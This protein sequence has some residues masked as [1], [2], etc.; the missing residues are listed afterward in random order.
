M[1]KSMPFILK[2]ASLILV[3]LATAKISLSFATVAGNATLIWIP[4]GIALAVVLIGGLRYLPSVFAG[5]FITSILLNNPLVINL[6]AAIGNTLEAYVGYILLNQYSSFNR[7]LDSPKDFFLLIALGG[8]LAPIAS[9][10]FGALALLAENY[11]SSDMLDKVA[12]GWWRGDVIGITYF[13]PIVLLLLQ[14]RAFPSTLASTLEKVALWLIS[15]IIGQMVFLDWTPP[16]QLLDTKLSGTAWIFL[17]IIWASQRTGRRNTAILQLMFLAQGLA[18]AY[19]RIGLFADDVTNYGMMN[20][21]AFAMLLAT[22]GMMMAM[23]KLENINATQKIKLVNTQL[24]TMIE[25]IPDAVFFKDG[26]GRWLVANETAKKLFKLDETQWYGKTDMELVTTNPEFR[27]THEASLD[28]DE[29]TWK[30]GELTLFTQTATGDDGLMHEYEMRKVPVL[31]N[32]GDRESLVVIGR[33]ITQHKIAQNALRDSEL[34]W[35][36]AI[37][38][39]DAG[40]WEY[41]FQTK[42]NIASKHLMEILGFDVESSELVHPLNDWGE[43]L[44]PKSKARTDVAFQAIMSNQS[45]NYVVEQEVRCED[46][47][48]KWLLTRGMVVERDAD[49]KPLLMIGT[50]IDITERQLA[51]E[52]FHSTLKEHQVEIEKQNDELRQAQSELKVSHD[53]YQDLYDFSPTGY[54]TITAQG[55]ITEINLKAVSML[56]LKRTQLIQQRLDQ[57]VADEDKLRLQ[58]LLSGIIKTKVVYGEEIFELK[59]LRNDGS[60][61]DAKLICLPIEDAN[62][63]QVLRVSLT[64]ITKLKQSEIDLRIAAIAFESQEGMFVTDANCMILR[65]NKAF[66]AMTGYTSEDIVG[67]KPNKL[68]SGRHDAAFYAQIWQCIHSTGSWQG[69]VWNK[70]KQG[71][72]Y[73]ERLT[74]TSVT[75]SKGLVSN[76]VATMIDITAS[77]NQ[78]MQH[79]ANEKILRDTL[80]RE[81]HH[82]IKN[83]LQGVAGLLRNSVA[84]NPQLTEPLT[85][86]ISQVNSISVIHGLQG[87]NS[88][89]NIP[90]CDLVREIATNNQSLWQ[91]SITLDLPSSVPHYR[92]IETETVPLALVLNELI[93]NAI[94]H[95]KK[96]AGI[97]IALSAPPD[98]SHPENSHVLITITNAGSLSAESSALNA[99]VAGIGLK[100]VASLLPSEGATLSWVQ[101]ADHVNTVLQLE[102]PIIT[103][104]LEKL[105]ANNEY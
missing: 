34:R 63:I 97:Q 59:F 36:F 88:M 1:Q 58:Q 100:L 92:I 23:L 60:T 15:F 37:E 18:S 66:T 44:H 78:E 21:W 3:Y 81:V 75:D 16:T 32:Q 67:Q 102:T 10:T 4:G 17:L 64:D 94:K 14:K 47:S 83:N 52:K 51:K 19:L 50:S 39:S 35:K 71:D 49:G 28:E 11:I 104:T 31:S 7:K 22:G 46:G 2:S 77:K 68:S 43:R 87:H 80:V 48:Y 27:A 8:V 6:G 40:M 86:A 26:H 29:K 30:A 82:R 56:G 79:Q 93:S 57:F 91:T 101:C 103:L 105:E 38:G 5:A 90:L 42:T 73:P 62:G 9:V 53:R 69:E 89:S 85:A 45:A 25:A 72:I 20:F 65:V 61:F 99:P 96:E 84:L 12:V 13:T 74:I 98:D 41:N 95:G 54:L 76:Y 70:R 24:H 55:I 33:D